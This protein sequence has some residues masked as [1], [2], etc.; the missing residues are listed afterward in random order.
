MYHTGPFRVKPKSYDLWMLLL[1]ALLAAQ[2]VEDLRARKTGVDWPTFLG[3]TQD[4][5]SPERGLLASW[6]EG[7][8]RVVWQRPIGEG[9]AP[10]AIHKGRLFAVDRVG[11]KIWT[12][13]VKS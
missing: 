1:L 7:G 4:S 3:P 9:Y 11:G 8:P 2:D 13:A 6:P 5:V 12:T 10:P